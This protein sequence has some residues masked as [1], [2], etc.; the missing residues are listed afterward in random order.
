MKKI[1]G[2]LIVVAIVVTACGGDAATTQTTP[3]DAGDDVR[4]P[5]PE[6]IVEGGSGDAF[7][8]PF[9][10][11]AAELIAVSFSGEDHEEAIRL[12]D[13][14]AADAPADL[15]D[16]LQILLEANRAYF[17]EGDFESIQSDEV[18]AAG[19]RVDSY[20]AERCAGLLES[21]EESQFGDSEASGESNSY[22]MTSTGSYTFEH[23]GEAS[24]GLVSGQFIV[25]FY[26]DQDPDLA[27]DA[28]AFIERAEPGDYEGDFG[29]YTPDEETAL[30]DATITIESVTDVGNEAVEIQGMI[31]AEYDS[32]ELGSGSVSGSFRCLITAEEAA[33]DL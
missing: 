5:G 32:D 24:C 26:S 31:E 27:Y 29:F 28:L 22:E 17:E 2:A 12:L 33:G 13:E 10:L 20:L 7:S 21:D 16:D 15:I 14:L 19:D 23:S 4:D 30:G 25:E 3:A 8:D 1:R 9:C 6:E 11:K 18:D